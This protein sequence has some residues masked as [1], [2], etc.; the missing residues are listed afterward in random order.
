MRG[1][2]SAPFAKGIRVLSASLEIVP[3]R[4]K[5]DWRAFHHLPFRIYAGDANWVPPLL[6]ERRFHFDPKHNP[7]FQHAKAEFF[8]AKR[9]GEV[10]GRITAQVDRLHQERYRDATGHFGFIEAIDDQAVFDALLKA[11]EDWLRAQGM[12]RAIGPVSFALWDQPGL[13]VDGFDTPP[14]VMMNHHR[15]YYAARIAAAGYVKAEDL[16]AYSYGPEAST[17]RLEKLLARSMRSGEVTLRNIRMDKAHFKSEVA[18]LLDIINDAWSDNWGYVPMTKAEI[19]DLAGVLKLL[20]QPG[21]V[22]IAE[23]KGEPAAF[24]AIFPNLNEAIRDMKGRLFPF[25]WI[26]LLWRMKVTRPKTARM[27]M[28]GVRKALQSSPIGAA[29]TLSVIHSV[30]DFNF[31]HGATHGEL[32]W[33]LERNDRVRHVI[34]MVGGVPYKTYRLYEKPI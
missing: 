6:L 30:R 14:Q 20:L 3:A 25:N 19:D 4:S 33:I 5:A 34:E 12:Q 2:G 1:Y 24:A 9:G 11:A 28:M 17:E 22:A 15:P 18:M 13:L 8:I 7:Y 32:S 26:K 10:V 23:Y 21:D 29:L 31:A 27:P 16:I